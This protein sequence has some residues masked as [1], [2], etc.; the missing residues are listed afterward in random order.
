[1]TELQYLESTFFRVLGDLKDYL[2]E[3]T[4][5]GGWLSYIYAKYVWKNLAIKP[6]TTADIDFG[7]G[8]GRTG[9]YP[10]TIFKLLSSLDYKERHPQMDR[11]YPVVLYKDGKVRVDFIAPPNIQKSIIE[12]IVGSQININRIEKFDFLLKHRIA[13]DIKRKKKIYAIHCPKP[14]AFLYHKSATFIDRE[15]E[16]KQAKDLHYMYFILRYAPDKDTI[17]KEITQYYKQGHFKDTPNNLSPYFER[18]T[19]KGCL[20]VEKENGP[21]PYIDDLRQDIFERFN[22]MKELL[23][24]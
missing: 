7:L 6:V 21:D 1:L 22:R 8:A 24:K 2:D 20:M 17:L 11:M 23:Y 4:L 13:V 16:Q 10:K 14:S 15:D 18:K 5:V 9:V 3:L 19:S 12:K